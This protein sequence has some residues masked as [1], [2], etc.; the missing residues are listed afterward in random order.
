MTWRKL[1]TAMTALAAMLVIMTASPSSYA[2]ELQRLETGTPEQVG[3]SSARLERISEALKKEVSD[4]K[5]PGVVVV[6][7]RKGKIVYSGATGFQDK[8]ANKPM[9]AN[10]IFRIYSMTKPLVSVAAMLLVE[11]GVIQL[12]D[13]VSKFLPAFKDMQV[14]VATTSADGKVTY[15]NVP[16]VRPITVQD[17]LRH[18]AGLA[19]AEITKNEP[20]KGAY[21]EAKF[22]QPGVHEFDSRDMTPNEQVERI[23]K[24]PLVHQPGTTWEYSMAVDILGRVVEA[25]SG[26]RLSVFMDER[27]FQPLKM[28]DTSFWLPAGKIPRLAQPQA[29]DP[30][31]GQK[32]SVLDVSAEPANDSGGAG[33]L[34]TAM[35]YLRFGQMLL[36]GGELDGVRVMSR[37]TIKL[38]TS[39]HLGTRIA[40]PMQPGE[41][42]LGTQGY[43]FGL[44]FA[45]RQGDGVA[46]VPG[47][48]GEFMWAG[49]AGT[50]FWV[51]PKEAIVG[52]YLTQAPSPIRAY[53][54]KMFKTLVY[55]SLVD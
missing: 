2:R 28:V 44:G 6:V 35:D 16:A 54:R 19:Y 32:I 41:L 29:V 15:S 17:L 30:A 26:K 9:S 42:L 39:D 50:Y 52:V 3:M 7:A 12:T 23:A 49:Y 18:S 1:L 11:D 21:V 53:Y 34:S 38:M 43:T 10:S 5:L 51:D 22:S 46:G 40:T 8:G 33:A 24:A 14:S 36:N 48:A 37:S 13:P 27:L 4:G 45:V 20:V 31:S 55:Q 47:S 25:A